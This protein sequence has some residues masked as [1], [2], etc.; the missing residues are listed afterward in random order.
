[1]SVN[2]DSP[3]LRIAVVGGSGLIGQRH[4]RH[5][6]TNKRCEL[7]AIVDPSR[8][9][10]KVADAYSVPLYPSITELI[11]SPQK[12]H[13]AIVCT[14]N[15]T[16]VPIAIQLVR[17]GIHVLC[18]KPISGDTLS[19]V[20]LIRE[21][22][23]HN[24][25]LLIGHHRRFNPYIIAAKRILESGKLGE[26]T[27]VNALWAAM[28]PDSYFQG[29]G[30]TW[31]SSRA[32]G[33]GPILINFIHEIDLL[34][35]LLG[36]VKLIHA[37]KCPSRRRPVSEDTVEEGA[38]IMLNFWSGV[39]GTLLILDNVASPHNFEQATG[40][41]PLIPKSGRDVYRIFG[42][43]GTLSI[44]DLTISTY[45]ER[46]LSWTEEMCFEQVTVDGPDQAPF[47]AQLDHFISVCR[48][49]TRPNCTGEDG[50]RA[51]QVCEAVLQALEGFDRGVVEIK[52]QLT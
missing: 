34:Q 31:R 16:H 14:P 11:Q 5:V 39:V 21:A 47:D 43:S 22:K 23:E 41:N 42:T 32:G 37:V 3:L 38:A 46:S 15:T 8:T 7:I 30:L 40:E 1:M 36:P 35:Y 13:A 6:A 29:E 25:Q 51:L 26:I 9:A 49:E 24:V 48:G 27:A 33:G 17:A 52:P 2:A 20:G 45:G 4:C 18:E 44:P 10:A 12:P 50:L 19:A 28:K